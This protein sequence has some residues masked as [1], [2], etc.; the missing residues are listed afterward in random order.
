MNHWRGWS[1]LTVIQPSTSHHV[2][3]V[4]N[5]KLVQSCVE[6]HWN[7]LYS[8]LS[9]VACPQLHRYIRRSSSNPVTAHFND[10]DTIGHLDIA[11]YFRLIQPYSTRHHS[12]RSRRVDKRSYQTARHTVNLPEHTRSGANTTPQSDPCTAGPFVSF[13]WA[14]PLVWR[15]FQT[16]AAVNLDADGARH[17]WCR[18]RIEAQ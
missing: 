4:W 16:T 13:V 15:R 3:C 17:C 14:S 18:G 10:L 8:C 7:R 5:I 6:L 12:W 9:I 11:S 2:L 1:S